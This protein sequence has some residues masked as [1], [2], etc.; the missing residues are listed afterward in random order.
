MAGG[1]GF[2]PPPPDGFFPGLAGR[3]GFFPGFFPAG[4]FPFD[5]FGFGFLLHSEMRSRARRTRSRRVS[6]ILRAPWERLET[7]VGCVQ[8]GGWVVHLMHYFLRVV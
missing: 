5:G 7:D 6:R 3:A 2:P 8:N 4:F 1:F